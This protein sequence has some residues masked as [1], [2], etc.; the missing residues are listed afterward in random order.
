[1]VMLPRD[2]VLEAALRLF[3]QRGFHATGVDAIV[4]DAGVAKMSLYHHFGSKDA[5]I[6]AA[7]D[8]RDQR[9][10]EWFDQAVQR[11][12][13][14]PAERLLGVFDALGQWFRDPGFAG[15]LFQHAVAE[16]PDPTH[17][18]H[19][20]AAAHKAA[21]RERLETLGIA[22]GVRAPR[23]LADALTLLVDGSIA[24][25]HMQGRD[26]PA[27]RARQAAEVLVAH[28]LD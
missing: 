27:K 8:L 18:A 25:A 12:G 10:F 4:A 23:A 6:L 2:R 3:C 20:R 28:V 14:T 16:F 19:Q 26:V 11:A 22:A 7:L 13:A 9:W 1:M 15:C 24:Q 17:P 5:L 21:L